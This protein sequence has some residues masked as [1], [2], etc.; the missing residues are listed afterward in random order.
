MFVYTFICLVKTVQT[1]S[2]LM[3]FGEKF[4]L[5][6]YTAGVRE[7]PFTTFDTFVLKI[8]SGI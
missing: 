5:Y 6:I 8:K 7:A 2:N 4:Y 1:N 3:H